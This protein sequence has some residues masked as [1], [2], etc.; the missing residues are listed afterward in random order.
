MWYIMHGIVSLIFL[1]FLLFAYC[2]TQNPNKMCYSVESSAKTTLYSF[3]AIAA[4]LQSGVPHFQWIAMSLVGWCGMQ[5]AELL[6]WL[7]NPRNA[8]TTANKVVTLTL[9]PLV[10]FLQP[11]GTILGSFFVKPW[12]E[13]S[14]PRKSFIMWYSI[15]TLVTLLLYF[16][17]NL[18]KLCTTVTK[19][20]HLNWWP[21]SYAISIAYVTWAIMILTPVFV[22]WNISYKIFMLLCLVP[23]FGFYYGL[24]TDSKAS[25]WCYYTSF[26]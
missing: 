16:Y 9:I 15:I 4:L 12:N 18:N 5:F 21:S 8:C 13:C 14:A 2:K 25:V 26:T 3:I 17:G 23:G 20:G 1:I 19:G 22:L 7:T 10:L 24:T 6:L 11:F